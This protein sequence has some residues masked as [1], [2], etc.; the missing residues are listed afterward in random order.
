[1]N[2]DIPELLTVMWILPMSSLQVCP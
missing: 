2:T 1:M